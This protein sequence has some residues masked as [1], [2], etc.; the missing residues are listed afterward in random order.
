MIDLNKL[1]VERKDEIINPVAIFASLPNKAKKYNGYLRNVQGEVLNQWFELRDNKDNIIKMNTGSGKTA[2]ALLILQSCLNERKGNAVYVVPDNYLIQQVEDEAKDLGINVV[3]DKNDPSFIRNKSILVISIQKLINGKTIFDERNKID[4]II[5]DDVH[6]CIDIAE[7]QFIIRIDRNVHSKLYCQIFSIF[8]DELQRQNHY[9][10]L[11]IEEQIETSNPML[12]PFWEVSKKYKQIITSINLYKNDELYSNIFFPFSFVNDIIQYCNI[13]IS[14]DSIEISPD[15]LPMY[16]VSSF[17]NAKRR[18]FISATL[19]DDGKLLNCFNIDNSNIIKIITPSQALDIGNRMILYPQAINTNINDEDIKKYLKQI[20]FEKRIIVIVPSK[21]RAIFW[22]DVADHIFDKNNIEYI[23]KYFKGLDIL[24]NRYDGIDLKD[25]LCS[26]LV[27]DGL[28]N[29]KNLFGQIEE[30][31]LHDT[32]KSTCDKMQKIEQ[33]MGRGIRSNQD[34]CAVL[35]MGK[36]MLNIIYNEKALDNFSYSTRVQYDLSE[37]I[38]EQLNGQSLENIMECFELCLNKDKEW[39]SIVNKELSNIKVLDTLNYNEAELK[40][41]KAFQMAI[42][43]NYYDCVKIIQDLVNDENNQQLKGYYMFY[44]A[45]YKNFIDEVESQKIMLKAK[46]LNNN[47]YLPLTGYDYVSRKSQQTLQSVNIM[48]LLSEKYQNNFQSYLYACESIAS[49]LIFANDTYKIFEHNINNLATHL[50]FSS[51]MPD[52]E[53]GK[54]PDNLWNIGNDIFLVI[55]CKNESQSEYISKSDCGQLC[56]SEN[57]AKETYGFEKKFYPILIHKSKIFDKSASP[58]NNFRI[59]TEEKLKELCNNLIS[60][61]KAIISNSNLDE[62]LLNNLL[63]MYKL[64]SKMIVSH[65]SL[66]YEINNN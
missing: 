64:D 38:S 47:L 52:S 34:N 10:A 6:T 7:Q 15:C 65:Y 55:E 12:V 59:I 60:F 18:I 19:K 66:K 58:N 63:T 21:R 45:K 23:K 61:C 25:N 43:G 11:N 5:V 40:L 56:M 4:N 57:W 20:S 3:R 46:Q 42:K 28:P 8:K 41:N 29:A 9:N 17:N 16:K 54:G 13:V 31:I 24:V 50:G 26:Y 22:S 39:V 36:N 14:Y 2:V 44:L 30:S 53:T 27:I 49:N 48:N 1:M 35:I 32:T 62:S 51:N 37:K 33:G